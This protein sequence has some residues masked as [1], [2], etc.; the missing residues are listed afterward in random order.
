MEPEKST[1]MEALK[2]HPKAGEKIRDGV[3]DFKVAVMSFNFL[4]IV[5]PFYSSKL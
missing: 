5:L 2:F 4:S 3:K 1:L